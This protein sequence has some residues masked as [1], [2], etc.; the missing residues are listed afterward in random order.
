MVGQGLLL[1]SISKTAPPARNVVS[2]CVYVIEVANHPNYDAALNALK[3][4]AA[5]A[6]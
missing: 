4:K 2:G 6:R 1:A 3:G 5:A